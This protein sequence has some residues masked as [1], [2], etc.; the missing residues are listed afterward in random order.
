M[1]VENSLSQDD[2]T[3]ILEGYLEAALW[4][5]ED[6]LKSQMG[7]DSN[8]YNDDEEGES[9]IDKLIRLTSEFQRKPIMNFIVDNIDP[10][11]KIQAYMDIKTFITFAGRDAIVEA[12]E[13]NGLGKLGHDIWLT[14]NGHGAGFFDHSYE[15]EK[16][17]MDAAH[18]LKSVDLYITDDYK[19]VFSNA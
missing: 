2:L 14:R 7:D 18:K 16:N 1:E 5:E 13:E 4:T 8:M 6:N 19:L 10:D 11:S 12:I 15:F 9:D 17:L 3:E